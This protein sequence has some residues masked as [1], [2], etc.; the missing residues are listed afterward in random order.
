MT[1]VVKKMHKKGLELMPESNEKAIVKVSRNV[2]KIPRMISV[3]VDLMDAVLRS[4]DSSGM[5]FSYS[6]LVNFVFYKYLIDRTDAD[7]EIK[8]ITSK[9]MGHK[10]GTRKIEDLES[11][12]KIHNE[13]IDEFL[14]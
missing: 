8:K 3:N 12:Y 14:Y 9:D 7:I 13:L 4:F 2:Q 5:S 6:D 11:S 1:K 10:K